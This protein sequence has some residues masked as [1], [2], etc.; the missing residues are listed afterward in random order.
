MTA[1][2]PL[3]VRPTIPT[4][5]DWPKLTDTQRDVL[6]FVVAFRTTYQCPPTRQEISKHFG[7]ASANAA[8][9]HL[10][11]L[12]RKSRIRLEP[13]SRGIYVMSDV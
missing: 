4:N 11:A 2:S 6:R 5:G 8:E 12:Q 1:S 10:K 7:W 3:T 13:R 9:E